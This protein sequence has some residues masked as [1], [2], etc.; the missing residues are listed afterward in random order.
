M[1]NLSVKTLRHYHDVGVLE[2][3]EIDPSSGYRFYVPSQVG[4]AL[5]I[6]RLR[7]LGM[8]LDDVRTILRAPDHATRDETLVAHLQRMEDQLAQTQQSVE[9]LRSL[10][11]RSD[12]SLAVEQRVIPA[13]PAIAIIE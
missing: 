12:D 5:M 9:S 4:P 6:R 13:T 3:A 7:D 8:P 11:Q 2:P 1:T 10:L